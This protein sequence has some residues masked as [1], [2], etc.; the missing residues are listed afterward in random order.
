MKSIISLIALTLVAADNAVLVFKPLDTKTDLEEK[1]LVLIPGADV[2]TEFYTNTA[3]S[4]QEHTNLKLWVVVPAMPGKLCIPE[5]TN[6][7]LCAPLQ[8][9]VQGAIKDAIF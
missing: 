7:H 9:N 8:S 4:I 6:T 2:A 1:L 5:C 3:N